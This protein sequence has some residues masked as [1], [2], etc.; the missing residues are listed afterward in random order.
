MDFINTYME[1]CRK[2]GLLVLYAQMRQGGQVTEEYQVCPTKTRLNAMSVSTRCFL[3]T[4]RSG[5]R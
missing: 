4:G 5:I 3:P 2:E 1:R